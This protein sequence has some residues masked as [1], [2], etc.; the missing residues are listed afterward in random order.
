MLRYERRPACVGM[1]LVP[2]RAYFVLGE[3]LCRNRSTGPIVEPLQGRER[4]VS[5]ISADAIGAGNLVLATGF[6]GVRGAW[7]GDAGPSRRAR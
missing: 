6:V 3:V 7:A 5:M 1:K 2:P 4:V